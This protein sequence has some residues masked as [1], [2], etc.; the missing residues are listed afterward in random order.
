LIKYG[1][2]DKYWIQADHGDS[3]EKFRPSAPQRVVNFLDSQA[4]ISFPMKNVALQFNDNTPFD[5]FD[6]VDTCQKQVNITRIS[7]KN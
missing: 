2:K 7:A 3:S 4:A 1:K 5:L 6:N